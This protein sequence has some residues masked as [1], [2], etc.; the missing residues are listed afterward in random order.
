MGTEWN[1]E[2]DI[3]NL[4]ARI[5]TLAE[6]VSQLQD[7]AQNAEAAKA[8]RHRV[9]V[10]FTSKAKPSFECTVE[11]TGFTREE[12]EAESNALVLSLMERY[13]PHM[14]G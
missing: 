7:A 14:G 2:K 6:F 5:T 10:S 1:I 11:G 9:N 4:S 12:I 8:F 13:G 3:K